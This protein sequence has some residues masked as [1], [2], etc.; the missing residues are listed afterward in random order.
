[1]T[2]GTLFGWL[3]DIVGIHPFINGVPSPMRRRWNLVGFSV[4]DDPVN[5]WLTVTATPS[6]VDG[7]SSIEVDDTA[8]V[9][10][11][12][13]DGAPIAITS[14]ADDVT[15]SAGS[16]VGDTCAI[17][18]YAVT[19]T[20]SNSLAASAP[21]ASLTGSTTCT[22]SGATVIIGSTTATTIDGDAAVSLA[23]SDAN[24]LNIGHSEIERE[25]YAD[26]FLLDIAGTWTAQAGGQSLVL[27]SAGFVFETDSVAFAVQSDYGVTAR[28]SGG[29][30]G[31]VLYYAGIQFEARTSNL[32]TEA[33]T[34][35]GCT[36][37]AS[38]AGANRIGGATRIRGGRGSTPG[39]DLGGDVALSV[40]RH[41]A[42]NSTASVRITYGDATD[43]DWENTLFRFYRT[44]AA[45]ARLDSIGDTQVNSS[46]FLSLEATGQ[47][48]FISTAG[49]FFNVGAST[50][51]LYGGGS[52]LAR[53]WSNPTKTTLAGAGAETVASVTASASYLQRVEGTVFAILGSNW[54]IW[55]LNLT[56]DANATATWGATTITMLDSGGAGSG[57]TCATST[58][59][60]AAR[61]QVAAAAGVVVSPRLR[62]DRS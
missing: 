55:S 60:S 34:V 33:L 46:G 4:V 25:D 32:A 59:G 10:I 30:R 27:T 23:A 12:A 51:D 28:P 5:Q 35:T 9:T 20:G 57:W 48:S 43:D 56:I 29:G 54:A 26:T 52:S 19:C 44:A 47:I 45:R 16:G 2:V 18:G 31:V 8:G 42:D 38:A 17:S 6:L 11:T 62:L 36:A 58:S 37:W 53:Q 22:V 7:D 49:M 39:T 61:L 15:I 1:M 13:G 21:T 24:T 40:G 14:T 50:L 41:I 3:G